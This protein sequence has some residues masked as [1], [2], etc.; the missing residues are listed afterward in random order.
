M[1][2]YV[3]MNQSVY[4]QFSSPVAMHRSER[5]QSRGRCS[6]CCLRLAVKILYRVSGI[7]QP[8][9]GSQMKRHEGRL[10]AFINRTRLLGV[11]AAVL[12]QSVA[13]KSWALLLV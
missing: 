11:A 8:V 12:M 6:V 1:D 2:C 3:L 13:R 4:R 5:I 7:N 9:S 10:H